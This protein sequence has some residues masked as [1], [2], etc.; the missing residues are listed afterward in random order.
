MYACQELTAA[1]SIT[2][3]NLTQKVKIKQ[4]QETTQSETTLNYHLPSQ[5]TGKLTVQKHKVVW[6]DAK[7]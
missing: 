5:N 7:L 1:R 2:I 6:D 3:I 4:K